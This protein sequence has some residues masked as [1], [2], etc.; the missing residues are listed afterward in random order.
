M[1]NAGAIPRTL[2]DGLGQETGKSPLQQVRR[3]SS[4]MATESAPSVNL[5][6]TPASSA[7]RQSAAMCGHPVEETDALPPQK[8]FEADY[9]ELQQQRRNQSVAGAAEE[10][11]SQGQLVISEKSA[12]YMHDFRVDHSIMQGGEGDLWPGAAAGWD[13]SHAVLNPLESLPGNVAALFRAGMGFSRAPARGPDVDC[14]PQTLPRN[15]NGRLLL[16][17]LEIENF[18]SFYGRHVLG[19]LGNCVAIAGPNGAGKSNVIDAIAFA[20]GVN[21]G[22]LRCTRLLDLLNVPRLLETAA[23]GNSS[24]VEEEIDGEDIARGGSKA[25]AVTTVALHFVAAASTPVPAD[26]RLVRPTMSFRRSLT[27]EGAEFFFINEKTVTLAEY[28]DSLQRECSCSLDTLQAM[29]I[30]QGQIDAVAIKTPQELARLFEEVSGSAVYAGRY[31][32]AQVAMRK[33]REEMQR[34]FCR[35]S[36]LQQELR[37]LRKQKAE[38]DGYLRQKD[39]HR[40]LQE[41][42]FLFRFFMATRVQAVERDQQ[43]RAEQQQLKHR[44]QLEQL[45]LEAQDT[46]HGRVTKELELQQVKEKLA[47]AARHSQELRGSCMAMLERARFREQQREEV[48]RQQAKVTAQREELLEYEQQLLQ[49]SVRAAERLREAEARVEAAEQRCISAQQ[50]EDSQQRQP[51]TPEQQQLLQRLEISWQERHALE[52]QRIAARQQQLKALRSSLDLLQ[53]EERE[54]ARSEN[55]AQELHAETAAK[56]S[57]VGEALQQ[58]LARAHGVKEGLDQLRH[59]VATGEE[60]RHSLELLQEELQQQMTQERNLLLDMRR[61]AHEREV[62]EQLRRHVSHTGVYAAAIECC[63]PLNKRLTVAVAAALGERA[64]S[65][66]V[67]SH[68]LAVRCIDYLKTMRLGTRE[69]LPLESLR[70]RGGGTH[71]TAGNAVEQR[72]QEDFLADEEDEGDVGGGGCSLPPPPM[73]ELPPGCRWAVDC[74]VFED[75]FRP[76]FEFLLSDCV[77]V[78]TLA[79]A[80]Q[81]KYGHSDV[82]AVAAAG[83]DALG[84]KLMRQYRMVTLEGEKLLRNGVIAFEAGGVVARLAARWESQQQQR[85]T[86]RLRN[87]QEQLEALEVAE[88]TNS[89]K[90]LQRTAEF[91]A[92][93]R[94]SVQLQAKARVWGEQAEEKQQALLQLR[95]QVHV[96]Q[97]RIAALREDIR[98]KQQQIDEMQNNLRQLHQ[99]HFAALDRSVGRPHVRQEQQRNQQLLEQYRG[100]AGSLLKQQQALQAELADCR[101]RLQQLQRKQQQISG[102]SREGRLQDEEQRLLQQLQLTEEEVAQADKQREAIAGDYKKIKDD[103]RCHTESLQKIRERVEACQAEQRRLVRAA[104]VAAT[105]EQQATAE[106][107]QLLEQIVQQDIRLPLSAGSWRSVRV[108]VLG[109]A[110]ATAGA[111]AGA[112]DDAEDELDEPAGDTISAA[113]PTGNDEEQER[114]RRR[115]S[116]LARRRSSSRNSTEEPSG[117]AKSAGRQGEFNEDENL[118]C[119]AE[120]HFEF[121]FSKLPADKRELV[122]RSVKQGVTSVLEEEKQKYYQQLQQQSALLRKLLPNLKADEQ[123]QKLQQELQELEKRTDGWRDSAV[124]AEQELQHLQGCRSTLFL[125]CFHHCRAA[126]DFFF[127]ELTATGAADDVCSEGEETVPRRSTAPTDSAG[128]SATD[129]WEPLDIDKQPT[130]P[131]AVTGEKRDE[132]TEEEKPVLRS[133][134]EQRLSKRIREGGRTGALDKVGGRAFL[135]LEPLGSSSIDPA[136]AALSREDDAFLCGVS[137]LC[138]P[139]AKRIL[140]LHLLSGGERAAAAVSL[141]LALLSFLPRVPFLFLDEVDAALDSSRRKAL[142]RVLHAVAQQLQV[143]FISLKDQMYATANMLVG[144]VIERPLGRSRCFLLDLRPYRKRRNNRDSARGRSGRGAAAVVGLT[145]ATTPANSR[146]RRNDVVEA[147][148]L[149]PCYDTSPP[150]ERS[151]DTSFSRNSSRIT[152]SSLLSSRTNSNLGRSRNTLSRRSTSV[153]ASTVLFAPASETGAL[154]HQKVP[155]LHQQL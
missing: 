66:I 119:G 85:L 147:D 120:P 128:G 67:S 62:C 73:D 104:A 55:T 122:C 37:V 17:W 51:L 88:T 82:P 9:V 65:I 145:A 23:D 60:Q 2:G 24:A 39:Q 132:L 15:T 52:Q 118:R 125:R 69:F 113:K 79:V 27:R 57:E 105:R 20:L 106:Q 29:L 93:H 100:E 87:V 146:S 3:L 19:P 48:E 92:L 137:L 117:P 1:V 44:E 116:R 126:V 74:V 43:Q 97:Q 33:A 101:D 95:Q 47:K 35:C 25:G 96:Q 83:A 41:E 134:Y 28:R 131:P 18:K 110:A 63:Q 124:A 72:H 102:G 130:T 58:L 94:Q 138:M 123:Q 21:A 26:V 64:N 8:A 46:D 76:A 153:V 32:A 54:L 112:G 11:T 136:S 61:V 36:Q 70:S 75:Q 49:Q 5:D 71:R 53:E 89:E 10:A 80:Q 144:V 127:R 139:P 129:S 59:L 78:P 56:A 114:C 98:T 86:D 103:L 140:P 38:A 6:T 151:L 150:D 143:L 148:G 107:Q 115:C 42:S 109:E 81:L 90:L 12:E 7:P 154:S 34:L 30:F 84:S 133:M 45:L 149:A 4:S 108:A 99:H 22:Q 142:A 40:Q 152:S 91:A 16:R 141:V 31:D 155:L 50:P 77:I 135:E 13:G 14:M 111:V 68:E 121:D